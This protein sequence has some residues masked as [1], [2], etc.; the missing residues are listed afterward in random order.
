MQLQTVSM[1]WRTSQHLAVSLSSS[2]FCSP[3]LRLTVAD[4]DD[5]L[6]FRTTT[7]FRSLI[8]NDGDCALQRTFFCDALLPHI[9]EITARHSELVSRGEFGQFWKY[10]NFRLC[11]ILLLLLGPRVARCGEAA[12]VKTARHVFGVDLV[13]RGCSC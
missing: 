2:V 8:Y 12:N 1:L 6:D 11:L 7:Y 13:L 3:Q 9:T 5:F 4:D 10:S